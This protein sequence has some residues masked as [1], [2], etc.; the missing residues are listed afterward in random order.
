MANS[1]HNQRCQVIHPDRHN[2]TSNKVRI[3]HRIQRKHPLPLSKRI[4]AQCLDF[5]AP[6]GVSDEKTVS[7]SGNA[8]VPSGGDSCSRTADTIVKKGQE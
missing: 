8:G 2:T 1:I 3:I 5:P 6:F 7:K 4:L